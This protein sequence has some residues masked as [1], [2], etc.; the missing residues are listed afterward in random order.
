MIACCFAR[1]NNSGERKAHPPTFCT[2]HVIL[3]HNFKTHAVIPYDTQK[4]YAP[5]KIRIG[6]S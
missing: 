5:A 3:K 6:I 2:R 4:Y 1:W